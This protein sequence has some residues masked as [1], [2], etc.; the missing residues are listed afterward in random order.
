M[1]VEIVGD[2]AF[3]APETGREGTDEVQ[4]G[5]VVDV[6]A[7]LGG[8]GDGGMVVT[9]N[10]QVAER[11]RML[12]THG[13]RQKY[14]PEIIGFNSRLDE[15]QAAILRV[16]LRRLDVWNFRRRALANRYTE[17]L[18]N[19]ALGLPAEVPPAEH[20]YH[21]YVIRVQDRDRVQRLLGAAGIATAVYYPRPLHLLPPCHEAG[22]QPGDFP[23]AEQ[24]S[25]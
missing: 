10:D 1:L 5:Q 22:H 2:D 4:R 16:K 13:W 19:L 11:I 8:I 18:A 6:H 17:L 9:G 7:A 20:V 23:V 24:A 21:L 15:L 12:R 14:F 3:V 25:Y